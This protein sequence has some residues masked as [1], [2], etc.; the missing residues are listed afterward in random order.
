VRKRPEKAQENPTAGHWAWCGCP[1]QAEWLLAGHLNQEKARV[2][3]DLPRP[4]NVCATFDRVAERYNLHAALEQEVSSRLLE[5]LEFQRLVPQRIADLG[6]GTGHSA[7]ALK[8]QFPRAEVIALD[9]SLAMCRKA[10]Q[11]SGF[12][13]PLRPVCADLAQ[14]PLAGRCADLLFSNLAMQWRT[15]FAA[16]AAGFRRVL[17]TGGLLVFSTLG[18]GSLQEFQRLRELAGQDQ[19]AI[20]PVRSFP[21]MHDIG[22]A[23][24]AAGFAEPVVDSQIITTEY[25]DFA[26]L[27]ADLEWT[28]ASSH[29]VDWPQWTAASDS[30]ATRYEQMRRQGSLPVT[31]EIV[32]GAAFGPPEGQP[33]KTPD[34]DV[35]A[36]SV[37]SLRGS[38]RPG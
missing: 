6:A 17:K 22:D 34:G 27:L 20:P 36:F 16:L 32:F 12:F 30:L 15:D 2:N 25:R 26:R 35:A 8:R 9:V 24:L 4:S 3:Q 23:L 29:F 37:E 28:G 14:L 11:E 5:R 31:W 7:R 38:R 1:K 18:P 19:S 21:D 13:R 10:Q 33:I